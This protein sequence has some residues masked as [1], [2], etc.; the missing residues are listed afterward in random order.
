MSTK[1]PERISK[2]AAEVIS[3]EKLEISAT[4]WG[5]Q[6]YNRPECEAV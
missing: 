6:G 3:F 2:S 1:I 4:I 5:R